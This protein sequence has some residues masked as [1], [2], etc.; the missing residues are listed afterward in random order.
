MLVLFPNNLTLMQLPLRC[1]A[2]Q[3]GD[4]LSGRAA[5]RQLTQCWPF[6]LSLKDFGALITLFPQFINQ[7]TQPA[8]PALRR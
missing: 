8:E 4:G 7:K 2:Q 3:P 5:E 1:A 6:L